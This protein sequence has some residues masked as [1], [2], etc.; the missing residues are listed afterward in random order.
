[1]NWRLFAKTRRLQSS[2]QQFRPVLHRLEDRTV[3]TAYSFALD[4]TQSALTLSATIMTPL[5]NGTLQ[6]QAPG[7]LTTSYEGNITADVDLGGQTITFLQDPNGNDSYADIN[8]NWEPGRGGTPGT[9]DLADYGGQGMI[10]IASAKVAVRDIT[11]AMTSDPTALNSDGTFASNQTM[12]ITGGS[13]DYSYHIPIFGDGGGNFDLT[14]QSSQQ[15]PSTAAGTLVISGTVY[16]LVLP[17]NVTITRTFHSPIGDLTAVLNVQGALVG[18]V[19]TGMVASG[20]SHFAALGV[21]LPTASSGST[22]A[23]LTPSS[24]GANA[25]AVA[26]APATQPDSTGLSVPVTQPAVSMTHHATIDSLAADLFND[27]GAP[28]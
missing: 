25:D 20:H 9:S 22:Q 13:A 12:V 28:F 26:V 21:A 3:P 5:G 17:V 15:D 2:R 6:E 19:D 14:G 1:M 27:V 8:G 10:S 18:S 16:T 7:S 23:L 4:P 11:A 24:A